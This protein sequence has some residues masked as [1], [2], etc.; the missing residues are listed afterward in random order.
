M[1]ADLVEEA[2]LRT[3]VRSEGLM[4][5]ANTFVRKASQGLTGSTLAAKTPVL[6]SGTSSPVCPLRKRSYSVRCTM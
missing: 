2:Q 5:S 4:V 1:N 6:Y 3:G